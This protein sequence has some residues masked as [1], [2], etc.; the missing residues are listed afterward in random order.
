MYG[1]TGSLELFI[2]G[3]VYGV[4]DR[5]RGRRKS[6]R[7]LI[8]DI[9]GLQLIDSTC[10]DC[11][12]LVFYLAEVEEAIRRSKKLDLQVT[13]HRQSPSLFLLGRLQPTQVLYP[14]VTLPVHKWK[15]CPSS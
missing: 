9:G 10:V 5:S 15:N 2:R 12:R 4:P 14:N 11:H 7:H 1:Y 6:R 8:I 13:S 3:S